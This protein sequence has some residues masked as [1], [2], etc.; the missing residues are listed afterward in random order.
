[1]WQ[2]SA[3]NLS[4]MNR[5]FFLIILI[6]FSYFI[7]VVAVLVS[8]AFYTLLERKVLGYIQIRKGPNKVGVLG[9]LQPFSDGIKLLTKEIV[10]PFYS[11]RL[12]F[13]LRPILGLSLALCFWS[14]INLVGIRFW[15][16]YGLVFFLVISS[17]G[18][19]SILGAGWS[20]NSI[21]GILGC[22]RAVAQTISYEVRLAIILLGVVILVGNYNLVRCQEFSLEKILILLIL[23]GVWFLSCLAETNRSP[24]DFAEGESE[25]VSGFNIEYG[26]GG[27]ALIFIAEYSN[28]IFISFIRSYL[29]F[30]KSVF[31]AIAIIIMFLWV[32][33]S[34]PRYRYDKLIILAWKRLLPFVLGY[35]L[36]L[37]GI[38]LWNNIWVLFCQI[39]WVKF[40]I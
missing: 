7:L 27:F 31:V 21:Y 25:L 26:S 30:F 12:L 2:I 6:I 24:F 29:F 37:Y 16:D 14:L 40:R 34:F 18:I 38:I 39:D 32:R 13:Y 35:F 17:L 22:Y 3:M 20:S 28:I 5:D 19:Y 23:L 15:Y 9:L 10:W 1:M 8:V 4:F 36:F 33:G 11:N